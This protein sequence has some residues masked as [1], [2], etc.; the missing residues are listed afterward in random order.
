MLWEFVQLV[1]IYSLVIQRNRFNS[2]RDIS[3]MMPY[4]SIRTVLWRAFRICCLMELSIY[5]HAAEIVSWLRSLS[6]V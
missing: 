4:V 3:M 5:K 6:F 1:G 2:K